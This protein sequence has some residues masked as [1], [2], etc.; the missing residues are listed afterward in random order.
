MHR[1]GGGTPRP[2]HVGSVEQ[3]G[4]RARDVGAALTARGDGSRLHPCFL[5]GGQHLVDRCLL[6]AVQQL[7][8]RLVDASDAG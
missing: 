7:T 5:V 2:Q 4:Q 1:V 6:E 8:D 3:H